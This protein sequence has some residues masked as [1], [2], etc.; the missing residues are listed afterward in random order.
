MW[1][2]LFGKIPDSLTAKDFAFD[3]L[4]VEWGEIILAG[5]SRRNVFSIAEETNGAL[6]LWTSDQRW[7][8]SLDDDGVGVR[9]VPS[10]VDLV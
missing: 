7:R 9:S 5:L 1:L 10:P 3:T 6:A 4:P 2:G 8:M